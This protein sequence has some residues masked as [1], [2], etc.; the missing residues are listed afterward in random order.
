MLFET[1]VVQVAEVRVLL[2]NATQGRVEKVS[3]GQ[4]LLSAIIGLRAQS[5]TGP[6]RLWSRDLAGDMQD[7]ENI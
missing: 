2:L 5:L 3:P 1:K 7:T 4:F 6:Q